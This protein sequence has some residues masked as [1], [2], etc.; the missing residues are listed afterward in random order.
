MVTTLHGRLDISDLIPLY[1]EFSEQPLISIS[2]A[3][4]K[5]LHWANWI[6]TVYHGLPEDLYSLNKTPD[7]Y[8]AFIGRISPEKRLDLA[9][10]IAE[11]AGIPLKIAAKVDKVDRSIFVMSSDHL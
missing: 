1:R 5:P 8:L 6:R 11:G 4:R 2:N 10:E 3:Q 9:I 7:P